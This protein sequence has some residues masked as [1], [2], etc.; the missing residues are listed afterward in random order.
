[1]ADLQFYRTALFAVLQAVTLM[2]VALA[3]VPAVAHA[4]QGH[5][6]G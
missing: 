5:S 4:L 6:S 1:V 3:M 2:L